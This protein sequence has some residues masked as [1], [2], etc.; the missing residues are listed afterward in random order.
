M[1][2]GDR[3]L[4]FSF[5]PSGAYF[6]NPNKRRKDTYTDFFFFKTYPNEIRLV[7]VQCRFGNFPLKAFR[8]LPFQ[9]S[10][11]HQP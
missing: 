8:L 4:F 10:Q 9:C 2:G 3:F 11:C 7:K 1:K 5:R 6:C